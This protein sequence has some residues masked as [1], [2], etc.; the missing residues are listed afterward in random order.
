MKLPYLKLLSAFFL[1]FLLIAGIKAYQIANIPA[2]QPSPDAI[3]TYAAQNQKW[4]TTFAATGN[5]EAVQGI[6]LS[7]EQAGTVKEIAKDSGA[8][9]KA[10]DVIFRFDTEVEDAQLSSAAAR[11]ELAK[12]SFARTEQLLKSNGISRAEY[13]DASAELKRASADVS[14]VRA[15]INQKTVTA[16]F[17]GK[18]GIRMVN[19]GQYVKEGDNLAQLYTIDPIFVNFSIPQRIL[20]SIKLGQKIR[21]VS[22]ASDSDVLE[23]EVSA[24]N[25]A[26]DANSRSLL[27]QAKIANLQEKLKPGMFVNVE[28]SLGEPK[29]VVVIPVT[30]VSY[31]PYGNSIFL[32]E[33]L[34]DPQGNLYK[35]VTQKFVKLGETKGDL[36]SIL[37]GVSAGNEIA[38]SAIFKLRNGSAVLVDNSQNTSNSLNPEVSES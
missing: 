7:T 25:P 10:G 27:L 26:M 3:S 8:Q 20:S 11:E 19:L 21:V 37:E 30:A 33:M 36:V 16:P 6:M 2:W 23:G 31:A 15:V 13:D 17:D 22:D 32:V 24:I 35:G 14:A 29:D 38:A 1:I 28:L 4:T 12:R 5:I 18:L 9:V 34:K